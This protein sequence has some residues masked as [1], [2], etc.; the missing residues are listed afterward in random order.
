VPKKQSTIS[1]ANPNKSEQTQEVIFKVVLAET[2]PVVWRRI[3]LSS[4]MTLD[5]LSRAIQGAFAWMGGHGHQ[6]NFGKGELYSSNDFGDAGDNMGFPI[7]KDS[8]HVRLSEFLNPK[9]KPFKY[10]YDFGDSWLHVVSIESVTPMER[11]IKDPECIAGENSAPPQDCG[12][13]PGFENFK[14]IMANKRDSE[15]SS[16]RDW[17]GGDFNPQQFNMGETNKRIKK[18]ISRA[19]PF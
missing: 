11:P 3:K 10:E 13:T 14:K 7:P 8:K 17:Y 12:G 19:P 16:M 15:H 6:F 4:K 18:F 2:D 9:H 1:I 5:D